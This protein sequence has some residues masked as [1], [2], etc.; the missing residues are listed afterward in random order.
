LPTLPEDIFGAVPP[1]LTPSQEKI[2]EVI[3]KNPTITLQEIAKVSGMSRSSI[4]NLTKQLRL[5]GKLTRTGR[6]SDGMW[7]ITDK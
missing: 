1:S 5:M 3:R 6:R 7:V 2:L 4:A